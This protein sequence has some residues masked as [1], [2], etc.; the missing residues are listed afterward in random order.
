MDA[1]IFDLD[2]VAL[3][4]PTSVRRRDPL[5][6]EHHGTSWAEALGVLDV[7]DEGQSP[8]R[9]EPAAKRIAEAILRTIFVES[10]ASVPFALP[11]EL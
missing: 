8:R 4:D 11:A 6:F 2:R 1:P 3:A 5:R 10:V 9:G 7:D